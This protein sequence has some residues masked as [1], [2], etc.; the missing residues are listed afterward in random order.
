VQYP[1]QHNE[2]ESLEVAYETVKSIT[3]AAS[4]NSGM[5]HV[6]VSLLSPPVIAEKP[7]E[8]KGDTTLAFEIRKADLRRFQASVDHRRLVCNICG[9][10]RL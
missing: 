6:T 10:A 3:L 1:F 4:K 7:I 5:V 2:Y 9:Y 8:S